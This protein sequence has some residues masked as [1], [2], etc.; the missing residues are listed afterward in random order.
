[1]ERKMTV[2]MYQ[3][4][5]SPCCMKVRLVLAEKGVSWQ[6]HFLKS[7]EF[8][9]FQ[10][11]YLELNPHGIVPTLV[12]DG[13][14]YIQSN[15]IVE[16]LDDRF[17][18]GIKLKPE[19]P[20]L[21]A[22]MRK[23]MFEEQDYLFNLIVTMSFNT[24]MKLRVEGYGL[25][26]LQAWSLK[27]PDQERAQDYLNRLNAP[28]NDSADT[29]AQGKYRWHM[30]RLEAELIASDGPWIC[31]EQFSLA[32]ICVAP[33]MDRIEYLDREELWQGLPAVENWFAAVK[34]RPSYE[35]AVH[36]FNYRMWGPR[37]TVEDHPYQD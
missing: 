31:G 29:K 28:I 9:H 34:E 17:Q 1:M 30:E 18:G 5:D 33:I 4:G 16:Y 15:V 21:Q 25:E 7:W 23:W 35:E 2:E 32:D 8:E 11:D 26:R 24:M 14:V 22:K 13:Q 10:P 6:E 20:A 3:F 27:H 12:H 37:K 19:D 36:P